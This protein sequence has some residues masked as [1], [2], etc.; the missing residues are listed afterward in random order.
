MT[1]TTTTTDYCI[2]ISSS[3]FSLASEEGNCKRKSDESKNKSPRVAPGRERVQILSPCD[4]ITEC[5]GEGTIYSPL[6]QLGKQHTQKMTGENREDTFHEANVIANLE[7]RDIEGTTVESGKESL[8]FSRGP[9]LGFGLGESRVILYDILE[10][11][12][13]LDESGIFLNPVEDP[14]DSKFSDINSKCKSFTMIRK[15]I[16]SQE[17]LSWKSFVD[18]FEC[19]CNDVMCYYQRDAVFWKAANNMLHRGRVYLDQ[20]AKRANWNFCFTQT[21]EQNGDQNSEAF[22]NQNA[23]LGNAVALEMKQNNP[24]WDKE[25]PFCGLPCKA[26]M[27]PDITKDIQQLDTGGNLCV[28]ADECPLGQHFSNL[29]NASLCS[30]QDLE[31]CS[32]TTVVLGSSNLAGLSI[33]VDDTVVDITGSKCIWN[34]V[35]VDSPDQ[36]TESSSSFGDTDADDYETCGSVESESELHNGNAAAA[37]DENH[38]YASIKRKNSRLSDDW[39]SYRRGIEWR[40]HWLELQIK[41]FQSQA[42][43]YDCIL[44]KIQSKKLQ[45]DSL[46]C[47]KDSAARTTPLISHSIKQRILHR[48]PKKVRKEKDLSA[49]MSQHPLFSLYENR[50]EADGRLAEDDPNNL[51]V[52]GELISRMS[53]VSHFNLHLGLAGAL[54]GENTMELMLWNI[55]NLQS[56]IIKMR[57]QLNK[58]VKRISTNNITHNSWS[59][60]FPKGTV[61]GPPFVSLGKSRNQMHVG[62]GSKVQTVTLARRRISEFDINNVV[63]PGNSMA[64]YVEPARHGFIETP[65]W[66]FVGDSMKLDQNTEDTSEEATDDEVYIERHRCM[67]MKEKYIRSAPSPGKKTP[68]PVPRFGLGITSGPTQTKTGTEDFCTSAQGSELRSPGCYMPWDA[69]VPKGKRNGRRR[70]SFI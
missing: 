45:R 53:D 40:C 62:R 51:P 61:E 60:Q 68:A 16:E 44:K 50:T 39:K 8:L 59:N 26:S 64:V 5:F 32:T 38:G 24:K 31:N 30:L 9:N 56:R 2:Q 37:V 49:Y 7:N 22:N 55:E 52:A 11:L 6:E 27:Q 65:H 25:I 20:I 14:L 54:D 12:A 63:M 19:I 42:S 70:P 1:V 15:K 17:Y 21:D 67:E 48:K 46:T 66:R 3:S 69:S 4:G 43:K 13:R 47:I 34:D 36:A 58:F 57:N 33:E 28:Q 23:S 41:E 35:R 10:G 29:A 18:D